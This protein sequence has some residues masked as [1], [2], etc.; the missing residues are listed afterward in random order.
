MQKLRFLH[1][2]NPRSG[3][4]RKQLCHVRRGSPATSGVDAQRTTRIDIA[5]TL[6][7]ATLMWL[8]AGVDEILF[9]EAIEAEGRSSSPR[10]PDSL[11]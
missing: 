2:G 5:R 1:E 6:R 7:I 11:D 10:S 3:M 4:R 9:S 8:V